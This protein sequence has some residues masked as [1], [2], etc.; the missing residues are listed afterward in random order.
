MREFILILV[1]I[2]LMQIFLLAPEGVAVFEGARLSI[3]FGFMLIAAYAIGMLFGRLK[4]P[5]IVGYIV[6]GMLFGPYVLNFF[7][8]GDIENMKI[9]DQLALT[10]I[11]LNAG[12]ELRLGE[13]SDQKRRIL[14]LLFSL[15]LFIF[16]GMLIFTFICKPLIPFLRDYPP[17]EVLAIGALLGTLSIARSPSSIIAIIQ[18]CRAQVPYSET[19][20]GVTVAIDFLVIMIFAV[21]VSFAEAI[22]APGQGIDALFFIGV[23]VEV[24]A[25]V[26][27]GVIIGAAVAYYIIKVKVNVPVLLIV[28]A[29][30]IYSVSTALSAAI[31][32][33]LHISFHLEPLLIAISAGFYIQNFTRSGADFIE[34]IE[35]SSLPIYVLFF[36]MSGM[37]VNLDVMVELIHI[38]LLI[39]GVRALIAVLSGYAAGKIS[40]APALETRLYG[41]GFITQAGVSIGLA[42]EI[43]RRF[44]DWGVPL[45]TLIISAVNFNQLFGPIAFKYALGRMGEIHKKR[46][47]SSL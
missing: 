26:V 22:I 46:R 2:A 7:Q 23:G 36:A 42:Q 29:F 21:V 24:A 1:I 11:A 33:L 13:L 4:L 25:S 39:V 17:R 45:G 32:G 18:E 43:M 30:L 44:P 5:K 19:V 40:G 35:S 12:G 8:A 3:G 6:A 38:A 14:W 31:T 16:S 41:M 20:L 47:R 28:L 15:I 27:A 10:F 37:V 34:S 9:I